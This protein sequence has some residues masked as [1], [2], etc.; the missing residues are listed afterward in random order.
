MLG[1]R[2][3]IFRMHLLVGRFP[4]GKINSQETL[5]LSEYLINIVNIV[6]KQRN[7]QCNYV[8]CTIPGDLSSLQF[9]GAMFR[10][11]LLYSRFFT[12]RA[13]M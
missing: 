12:R 10:F 4:L 8:E 13:S 1:Q 3:Q 9:D 2:A 5:K 6:Y 11:L 7:V